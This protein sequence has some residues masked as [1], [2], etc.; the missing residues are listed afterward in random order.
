MFAIQDEIS[1]AVSEELKVKL[2]GE[3][4]K[5]LVKRPTEDMEA[6]NLYLKGIS[7]RSKVH[8]G[9]LGEGIECFQKAIE[10][11]PNFA[12][13][14]VG[15]GSIYGRFAFLGLSSPDE[16]Y[17]KAKDA[18]GKALKLDDS[19]GE[20]H[21]LLGNIYAMYGWDWPA[22]EEAFKKAIALNPG[23]DSGHA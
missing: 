17:P 2:L 7:L 5:R 18:L 9:E 16:V 8:P 1:T 4:K 13:A 6:Y 22:A 14:Y 3:K 11:D 21:A 20:A 12:L 10:R 23:L 19:L 15:M